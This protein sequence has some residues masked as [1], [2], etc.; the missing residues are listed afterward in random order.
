MLALQPAPTKPQTPRRIRAEGPKPFT[1]P[2]FKEWANNLVLDNGSPWKLEDWQSAF[3]KDVFSGVP[4]VWLVVPEGNGKTTLVAGIALYYLEHQSQASIPVAASSRDQAEILYRQASGFIVRTEE[5]HELATDNLRVVRGKRAME[6]PKFRAQDGMRRI[7]HIDGGRIKVFAADDRTGDGVIP[8]LCILDELH[9]HRDLGLYR[10]W[11]GKLDKRQG[12]IVV[13][14]TAGDP[15]GEFEAT[16]ET[17]RQ[18][19]TDLT[20]KGCF[21]R[22]ASEHLILHE[23]AVPED[24]N[25]D[26]MALVKSA[27]PFSGI[28]VEMLKRK[29]ESPTMTLEHW[30]RFVCNLPTRSGLAAITEA[31]W[32]GAYTETRIPPGVPVWLGLDVAWK[33]DTT[34]AVPLWVD[35][36][37]FRL[38][39]PAKILTPPRDGQSLDPN[40]VERALMDLHA[41]NPIHTVVMD[42][43]RA[44]QLAQWIRDNLGAEVIER[45]QSNEHAEEDYERFMEAL[46]L[47]WL[48]HSGDRELSMHVL[49]AIT[50][51]TPS[52]RARFDRISG[53]RQGG[54]QTKRVIDGLSAA[55]MVHSVAATT[56]KWQAF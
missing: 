50:R 28:T 31:E 9:R 16:R 20:R 38:L 22:A 25:V 21:V 48:K 40:L 39:G 52:G 49:N 44:E 8:T 15:G 29:R 34:A 24:G 14:S 12:Q 5:M 45:T 37:D 41:R 17:I 30:R 1:L 23:W 36:D 32:V 43:S 4:E 27:N 54:D 51:V 26:D 7:D 10:T 47:G 33:W 53:T 18:S 42:N 56:G 35:R 55:G 6:V 2:H 11:R 46:R 3:V 13:I 19:A